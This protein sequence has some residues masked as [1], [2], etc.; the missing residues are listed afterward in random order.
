V[1]FVASELLGIAS[2]LNGVFLAVG[3][4]VWLLW[5]WRRR[6]RWVGV[7]VG[8][9]V[10]IALPFTPYLHQVQR[11]VRLERLFGVETDFGEEH[12]LRGETTLHPMALPYSAFAFAAGYSL[13]PTLEELRRDPSAAAQAR[14]LPAL[15]L[16]LVGFG[17]PLVAG[18]A[19]RRRTRPL[20][21]ALFATLFVAG[22][23]MWLAATN[24]KPFNVRYLS[25][26]LPV[27]LLVVSRGLWSLP[28]RLAQ[29]AAIAAL[30]VSLWSCFNYLFVPRYA[31]DDTRSVVAYLQEHSSPDDLVVHIN[32]ILPMRYYAG[33]LEAP[34]INA[35]PGSGDDPQAARQ[36]VDELLA[37]GADVLWYVECRPEAA[38]PHGNLR[39][40]L[41]E[42]ALQAEVHRFPGIRLYRF[43]LPS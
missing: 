1:L 25:V 37:R 32:L 8:L 5:A 22:V 3:L 24:M 2:N 12:R 21:P 10:L 26:L 43:D 31:R 7:W 34:V 19:Q 11:Q 38:D 13:G 6:L 39:R 40:A 28:H 18:V 17:V 42:A 27:F 15:F 36:Y 23:T 16:V 20:L 41:D 30:I 14:H 33:G 29:G 35:R 4:N 9:H